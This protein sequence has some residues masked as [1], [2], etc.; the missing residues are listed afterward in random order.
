MKLVKVKWHDSNIQHGWQVDTNDCSVALCEDVG[1]IIHEDD[2]MIIMAR[3]ISDH[4]FF[5]SPMAIPRGCIIEIKELR[6]K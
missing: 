6:C 4:A 3:G 5:N 1:W 2:K